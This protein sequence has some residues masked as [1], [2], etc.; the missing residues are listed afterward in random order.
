MNLVNWI[1]RNQKTVALSTMEAEYMA[2]CEAAK[3]AMYFRQ[4]L[5]GIKECKAPVVTILEDNRACRLIS[6]DAQHHN[7]A[8]HI[9][10]QYH[11]TRECQQRGCIEVVQVNT[12][13]QLA[14]FLT[15][16]LSPTVLQRLTERAFGYTPEFHSEKATSPLVE[17][18]TS[19]TT[20]NTP[21]MNSTRGRISR[22]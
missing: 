4:L 9:D 1:V 8:K 20:T 11:Y 13:R 21:T 19:S 6:K 22:K 12:Q 14:D 3:E 5:A 15:K 10:V 16:Y 2:L 18:Q 7:R 17:V